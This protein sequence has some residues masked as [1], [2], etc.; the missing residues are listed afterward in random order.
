[1]VEKKTITAKVTPRALLLV[2]KIAAK[3]GEKQYAVI[4]RLAEAEMVLIRQKTSKGI[5][6]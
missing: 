4:E 2:R 6:I 3:T 5:R 1:M